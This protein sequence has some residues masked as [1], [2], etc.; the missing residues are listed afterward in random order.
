MVTEPAIPEENKFI[1]EVSPSIYTTGV[2]VAKA[3]TAAVGDSVVV[4]VKQG[5]ELKQTYSGKL[6]KQLSFRFNLFNH[7]VTE[8][9]KYNIE[10]AFPGGEGELE[11]VYFTDIAE[12]YY[13]IAS[14]N[15]NNG[16]DGLLAEDGVITPNGQQA[17]G[18][19]FR[20]F[21]VNSS[22]KSVI[23]IKISDE[24][25]HSWSVKYLNENVPQK[26]VGEWPVTS[27]KEV[28]LDLKTVN[29]YKDMTGDYEVVIQLYSSGNAQAKLIIDSVDVYGGLGDGPD[30]VKADDYVQL[31][32]ITVQPSYDIKTTDSPLQIELGFTP[33]NA[34]F[35]QVSFSSAN[36]AIATVTAD[37]KVKGIAPGAATITVKSADGTITREVTVNV[38]V[39]VTGVTLQK[40]TETLKLEEETYD[41]GSLV[42]IAPVSATNKTV[43]YSVRAE[44]TAAATVDENG[45]VTLLA[46]KDGIVITVTTVDGGFTANFTLNIKEN[47]TLPTHVEITNPETSILALRI[48]DTYTLEAEVLPTDASDITVQ[49]SSGNTAVATVDTGGKVTAKL[50]GTAVITVKTNA[51]GEDGNA[52][53]ATITVVVE[54]PYVHDV[55]PETGDFFYI[56]HTNTVTGDLLTVKVYDEDTLVGTA[57]CVMTSTATTNQAM[58]AFR[59]SELGITTAKVYTFLSY[60]T[61]NGVVLNTSVGDF[62]MARETHNLL[63]NNWTTET[64]SVSV[65]MNIADGK[66]T[67]TANGT[68][69]GAA[70]VSF[71]NTTSSTYLL[72]R[73][74]SISNSSDVYT[75]K[76][77]GN[78]DTDFLANSKVVGHTL[79]NISGKLPA[80]Q[81][82]LKLFIIAGN[83][84]AERLGRKQRQSS[85]AHRRKRA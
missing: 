45:I 70:V 6:D 48:G 51:K 56:R 2:A 30:A 25:T 72:I 42:Q 8:N 35:K 15:W 17:W 13:A 53:E 43:T 28:T 23:K 31:T 11:K 84:G 58:A 24:S 18:H 57:S 36:T 46:V 66:A 79:V 26:T 71:N 39:A 82:T 67:L 27:K 37:G 68:G 29:E 77:S 60:V 38:R 16:T 40:A 80:G 34:S 32:D 78:P 41:V 63:T 74:V 33:E 75:L 44:D 62:F 49:W 21:T 12:R 4:N 59:V 3:G 83:E 14:E 64:H 54:Q 69:Y 47:V 55:N 22:D 10:V 76:K 81:V 73:A 5:S 7:N 85:S 52:L 20:T 9:G 19:V 1:V 50:I 61:R 65:T